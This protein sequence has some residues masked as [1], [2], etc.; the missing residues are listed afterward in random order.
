[1]ITTLFVLHGLVAIALLGAVSHQATSVWFPARKGDH[2]FVNRFRAAKAGV[3]TNAI[4]AL[5]VATFVLGAVAYPSYRINAHIHFE[6]GWPL[7]A[8]AFELKEHSLAVALGLLPAY[9]YYWRAPFKPEH[10]WTRKWLV[11]TLTAI[12]WAGFLIGHV[13][14]NI[15]GV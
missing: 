10:D 2:S 7:A 3:Y 14:N 15:Q 12:V 6:S 4:V 13:L 5:F 1:M 11:L 8:E 9:W